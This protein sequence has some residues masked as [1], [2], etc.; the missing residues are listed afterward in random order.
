[1]RYSLRT[2]LIVMLLG[3]PALAGLWKWWEAEKQ[4]L[5]MERAQQQRSIEIWST[6]DPK[7]RKRDP[8]DFS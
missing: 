6:P 3:G 5:E 2:L 4:R 1:M 8:G 7:E